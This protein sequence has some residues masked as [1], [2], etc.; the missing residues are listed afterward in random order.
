MFEL[1]AVSPVS[2]RLSLSFRYSS[3]SLSLSVGVRSVCALNENSFPIPGSS[4]LSP[5]IAAGLT[6]GNLGPAPK[7]K[8]NSSQLWEALAETDIQFRG[9]EKR[10]N[11]TQ[12]S[13]EERE[14][15]PKKRPSRLSFL[16][17]PNSSSKILC[18]ANASEKVRSWCS[19]AAQNVQQYSIAVLAFVLC[20][21]VSFRSTFAILFLRRPPRD[22]F[23]KFC[24]RLHKPSAGQFWE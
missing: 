5:L 2:L 12:R 1:K 13:T 18:L 8:S 4:L 19:F 10:L 22:W 14:S 16:A 24:G 20:R 17:N 6:L 23:W 11:P 3:V 7:S 21:H 9:F 15:S